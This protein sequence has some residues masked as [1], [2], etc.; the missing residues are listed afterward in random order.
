MNRLSLSILVL[1]FLAPA[2]S[3]ARA[4]APETIAAPGEIP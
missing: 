1:S 3:G 4:E 2:L